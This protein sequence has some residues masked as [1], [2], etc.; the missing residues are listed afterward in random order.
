MIIYKREIGYMENGIYTYGELRE[1]LK[2]KKIKL[3]VDNKVLEVN[4][5]AFTNVNKIVIYEMQI[6]DD[7]NN[8]YLIVMDFSHENNVIARKVLSKDETI[9]L[10]N[11]I[12]KYKITID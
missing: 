7:N 8:T 9:K 12:V 2:N 4:G 3:E 6:G 5:L 1:K 11:S 10:Q